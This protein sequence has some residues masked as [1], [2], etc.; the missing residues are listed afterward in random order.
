MTEY[1]AQGKGAGSTFLGAVLPALAIVILARTFLVGLYRVPTTSMAGT[2]QV[3]DC[4]LGDRLAY[5]MGIPEPGDIVTFESPDEPGVTYVKRVVATEGQVVDIRDGHVHVD[6]LELCEP[7]AQGPTLPP[8][9]DDGA[10]GVAYP[11]VVA[12]GCVW[13]M[14]DNRTR[15]RDSRWFGDVPVS[16]VSSRVVCTYW[17]PERIGPVP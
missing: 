8:G 13:V 14:G 17:P 6:G 15:S 4:I 5:R 12:E 7:Y 16:S 2:I 1:Q 9:Q 11:H 3:G 10:A